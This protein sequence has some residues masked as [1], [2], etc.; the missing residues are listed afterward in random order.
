[1]EKNISRNFTQ[2]LSIVGT[3]GQVGDYLI[4][5]VLKILN[6]SVEKKTFSTVL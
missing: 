1:M 6:L 2:F 4:F 5:N 3:Y